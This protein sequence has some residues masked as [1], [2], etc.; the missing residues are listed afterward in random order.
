[1]P[2]NALSIRQ[3]RFVSALLATST[4]SETARKA[5]ISERTAYRYLADRDVQAAIGS[6]LDD[7]LTEAT[8]QVTAA[9]SPTLSALEV[10]IAD[11]SAPPAARVAA[12]RL[13]ID[14]GPRYR[15]TLDLAKRLANLED[16]QR[17]EENEPDAQDY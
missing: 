11:E 4:V 17:S 2:E 1:M 7:T 9:V 13:I 10:M 3:A 16:R 6:S 12:A 5:G 8:R 14:A 15:Q